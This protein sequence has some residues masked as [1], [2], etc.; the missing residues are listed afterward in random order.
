MIEV[1]GMMAH[2]TALHHPPTSFSTGSPILDIKPYVP[3]ADSVP[4]AIAPHWVQVILEGCSFSSTFYR[5]DLL[6]FT[7]L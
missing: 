1:C 5:C 4:E 7:T 6:S 2:Q 3:F